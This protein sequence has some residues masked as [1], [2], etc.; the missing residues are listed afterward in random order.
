MNKFKGLIALLGL[1]FY[2]QS[3][4]AQDTPTC[5]DTVRL[6]SCWSEIQDGSGEENY[7]N[8]LSCAFFLIADYNTPLTFWANDFETEEGVDLLTI[9]D[10]PTREHPVIDVWSGKLPS[11]KTGYSTNDTVLLFFTTNSSKTYQGWRIR[12]SCEHD[13]LPTCD[14]V[15]TLR[16]CDSSFTDGSYP[17]FSYAPEMNC[18]W[19]I[20]PDTPADYLEL[21]FERF[22]MDWWGDYVTIYDGA[23]KSAPI[24]ACIEHQQ[25]PGTYYTSGPNAFVEF[26][27]DDA[28]DGPGSHNGFEISYKCMYGDL[29]TQECKD[30]SFTSRCYGGIEDGSASLSYGNNMECVYEISAD[31]P[32]DS[33]FLTFVQYDVAPGDSLFIYYKNQGRFLYQAFSSQ[34]PSSVFKIPYDSLEVVFKT[35]ASDTAAG[36]ML[37]FEC[38][39]P[40]LESCAGLNKHEGCSGSFEAGATNNRMFENSSCDWLIEVPEDSIVV[41]N[42]EKVNFWYTSPSLLRV[43]D[44]PDANSKLIATIDKNSNN[45]KLQ[46]SSNTMFIELRIFDF[47]ISEFVR[48][49]W[50]CQGSKDIYCEGNTVVE[51]CSGR[52]YD[53]SGFHNYDP[54]ASCSWLLK[55]DTGKYLILDVRSIDLAAGDSLV[56]YDGPS[57]NSPVLKRFVKGTA[58]DRFSSNSNEVWVQFYT[59]N[60]YEAG[61]W[62]F[63]YD[64]IDREKPKCNGG[65]V[66]TDCQGSFEDGSAGENYGQGSS[67][68]W[69]IAPDSANKISL[70]FTD[71][72]LG[73][74]DFVKIYRGPDRWAPLVAT[75]GKDL[76][77]SNLELYSS[78][79]FVMFE[80]NYT[81][82]AQGWKLNYQCSIDELPSCSDSSM[83]TACSDTISDGSITHLKY[84]SNQ[85]C[86]WLIIP[87]SGERVLLKFHR[88]YTE[89]LFDKLVVY[90]GA[91][92]N[93]TRLASFSGPLGGFEYLAGDS[94]FLHF[95]SDHTVEHTGWELSYSCVTSVQEWNPLEQVW[96]YPNPSNDGFVKLH[97][98][99]IKIESLEVLDLQGRVVHRYHDLGHGS[100]IALG[101]DPG[102]YLLRYV[103]GGYEYL[104]KIL[105]SQ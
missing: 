46:S 1:V 92:T 62:Y 15:D 11:G 49:S 54:N 82:E 35:D 48:A 22:Y 21:N 14:G 85:D 64:C 90:Q 56:F 59:D 97:A 32:T 66:F 96:C 28:T 105:R 25:T 102:L 93:G 12:Y 18:G 19:L 104:Q 27:S 41:L 70:N 7:S 83:H 68:S 67:C 84:P 34:L 45:V 29:P 39:M 23:D 94:V 71:F 60:Q 31:S 53:G 81:E 10:G 26:T 65:Y 2:C 91:D 77:P 63:D 57:S 47:S 20:Q 58:K 88:F 6:Q 8:D 75:Y 44:G 3:I 52:I 72:D 73:D 86:T 95:T 43:F 87:E 76:P 42:L 101:S 98:P 5:M 16:S 69:L 4:S 9:Y 36:W 17:N 24:L 89:E 78:E 103:S 74:G 99:N 50:T 79:V 80:S 37:Y 100:R 33:L 30:S 13:P 40:T 38:E 51:S 61:G 55:P